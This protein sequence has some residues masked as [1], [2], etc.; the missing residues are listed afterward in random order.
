MIRADFHVH[1]HFSD[2]ENPPEE[3]VIAA[4]A[5]GF[6]TLGFSD[7]SAMGDGRSW[8]MPKEKIA[9]Y[10]AEIARLRAQYADQI[11]ILC[12]IEQD[13]YSLFPPEGYDYVIGSVHGMPRGGHI[14]EVDHNL[15]CFKKCIEEYDGD[16]YAFIED[17]YAH[18]AKLGAPTIIGHFDLVTK[19]QELEPLFDENHP[20]Y[21]EAARAA[22]RAL[23]P[24]GGLFEINVGA[25]SRK[26]RSTPYPRSALLSY[27]R[28]L[29]GEIIITGDCH[30]KEYLGAGFD[31]AV[32][33]AK[34]C[35]YERAVTL[36]GAGR[37][38]IKL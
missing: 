33:L 26:C 10:R 25:M 9:A 21:Q 3:M 24:G 20:R 14:C 31:I 30:D 36:T 17:Y 11:E 28:E 35:G 7:H 15:E 16:A 32:A 23:I 29:G 34:S 27:I 38:Y 2:G 37:E 12:G 4:I 22:A 8:G 19:F 6:K 1:T 13:Y 5:R 18:M